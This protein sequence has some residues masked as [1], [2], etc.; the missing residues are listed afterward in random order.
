MVTTGDEVLDYREALARYAGARQLVIQGSDHG[1][2][3]FE[4]HLDS[5]L[6]FADGRSL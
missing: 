2:A 3:D 6:A 4:Q 1:F 5:V